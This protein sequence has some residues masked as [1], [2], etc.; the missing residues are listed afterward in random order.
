MQESKR[1]TD[2][3]NRLLAMLEKVSVARYER[4]ALKHVYDHM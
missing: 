2:A 3:K 4:K 1:D